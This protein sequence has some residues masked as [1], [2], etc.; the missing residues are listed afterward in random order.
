MTWGFGLEPPVVEPPVGIE[1]TTFSLRGG[2]SASH[3]LSTSG[4]GNTVARSGR[5]IPH[6]YPPFCATSDATQVA[7]RGDSSTASWTLRPEQAE[8][9]AEGL[10][11]SAEAVEQQREGVGAGLGRPVDWAAGDVVG[12]FGDRG[13]G[14]RVGPARGTGRRTA[15]FTRSWLHASAVGVVVVAAES[16]AV[17]VID[18]GVGVVLRG[19]LDLVLGA[20]D[21]DLLVVV[22]DPLD[23]AGR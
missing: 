22:V 21:V 1:P 7:P 17:V 19:G 12:A 16:G 18:T 6:E 9:L 10:Q 3:L 13:G 23:H 8:R 2:T 15:G 11:A 5:E 14:T 4:S 20:V